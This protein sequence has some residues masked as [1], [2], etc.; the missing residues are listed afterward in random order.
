MFGFTFKSKN[1][2]KSKY[3]I[4]FRFSGYAKHTIK[5][6][7]SA[8]SR[9][10]PIS[11]RRRYVPHIT[12]VGP[13]YTRDAKRMI[14]EVQNVIKQQRT[15]P[16]FQ[17]DGFGMFE[18]RAIFVKIT[19]SQELIQLR[20]EIIERLDGFCEL[21][22]YDHG[23]YNPHAT[24]L[25][26]TDLQKGRQDHQ[27]NKILKYLD[28]WKVPSMKQDVLRITILN[29]RGKI[30]C[31]YD[32]ILKKLLDRQ[33][34]LDRDMRKKTLDQ[35][36]KKN[37]SITQ[38]YSDP[39]VENN[40]TFVVSDLHF[41]HDNIIRF[42]NRPFQSVRDMNRTMVDNWNKTV[43]YND[44]VYYLGD[45]T[46][47]RQ[48]RPID[49]W[50]SKLNGDILFIRGNHDTDIITRA[51]VIKDKFH[52]MYKEYDF[53]LMHDPYRPKHYD[54][55]I[56]HGDK[57]NNSPD[58]YPHVCYENKTINV[59]AEFTEYAPLNLGDVVTSINA[60]R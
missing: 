42:C 4:E 17:I 46:Y 2:P 40:R 14:A 26:N 12:L 16:T 54:G 48:R 59:C 24:L 11:S 43:D 21:G 37:S 30:A 34:A 1:K 28:S 7:Q 38:Q 29:S 49:F 20:K 47:G 23:T 51:T 60:R 3:L 58:E 13:L 19:P 6:L 55:W 41:D 22:E 27:F 39:V 36:R 44:R 50:L 8:I 52:I 57:H 32:L 9:N 25:L 31:E 18:G 5:D 15:V 53:L 56:I 35:W 45:M 10:F 33:D